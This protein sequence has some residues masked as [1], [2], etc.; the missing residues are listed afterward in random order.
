MFMKKKGFC[1]DFMLMIDSNGFI[2]KLEENL[3]KFVCLLSKSVPTMH[4]WL[5]VSG[6]HN[7]H[8]QVQTL[9]QTQTVHS[10]NPVSLQSL[11]QK[12][13]CYSVAVCPILPGSYNNILSRVSGEKKLCPV[14]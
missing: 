10:F 11:S 4:L 9:G 6:V 13:G 8:R 12:L 7:H 2:P 5:V 3:Q 14:Y 1:V